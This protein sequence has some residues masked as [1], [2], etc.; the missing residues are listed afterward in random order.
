MGR[1]LDHIDD[2]TQTWISNQ[3]MFFAHHGSQ[4]WWA[5]ECVA[6]GT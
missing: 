5:S 1:V 4:P 2:A 3:H 6:E